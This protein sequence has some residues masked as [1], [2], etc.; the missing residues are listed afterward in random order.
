MAIFSTGS[1][2]FFIFGFN[3]R[4][5]Q[6]RTILC[7]LNEGPAVD[8]LR[9]RR[10]N[11]YLFGSRYLLFIRDSA[12]VAQ[13]FDLNSLKL[14]SASMTIAPDVGRYAS[15][16]PSGYSA[17]SSA[18]NGFLTYSK[19][20][21]SPVHLRM[22]DRNGTEVATFGTPGLFTEPFV[23]ADGQKIAVTRQGATGFNDIWLLDPIRG[24]LTRLTF[25]SGMVWNPVVSPDSTQ[26]IYTWVRLG[27][28]VGDLF[29]TT[30]GAGMPHV[31]GN[32][33]W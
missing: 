18:N 10:F 11:G 8:L 22:Y 27:F 30:T 26:S 25:H 29:G 28:G 3:T 24:A 7:R 16:G 9:N 21:Y 33:V 5:R 1:K 13:R 19:V 31:V 6:T 15:F 14:T 2:P 32:P 4:T 23:S 12:L 20:P 17:F